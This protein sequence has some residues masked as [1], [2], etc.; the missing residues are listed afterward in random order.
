MAKRMNNQR[1]VNVQRRVNP[2]D[3]PLVPRML[4]SKMS[5]SIPDYRQDPPV[6]RVVRIVAS[7]NT[8]SAQAF[9]PAQIALQDQNNY[10]STSL[11]YQFL[12]IIKI[13]IYGDVGSTAQSPTGAGE[14]GLT[15]ELYDVT[16]A[17]TSRFAASATSG[18]RLATMHLQPSI[19]ICSKEFET[20]DTTRI[21]SLPETTGF[22]LVIVDFTVCFN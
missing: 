11:R 22:E 8:S 14:V 12:R 7:A 13:S 3:L 6:Y 20:I 17:F 9:A 4:P 2:Q 19:G 21:L 10:G 5:N 1:K 18:S 15:A 16:N